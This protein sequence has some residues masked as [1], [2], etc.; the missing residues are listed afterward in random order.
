MSEAFE[1]GRPDPG[2]PVT[3]LA[4]MGSERGRELL[5]RI[6]RLTQS[7]PPRVSYPS[8]FLGVFLF[9]FL[10][11]SLWLDDWDSVLFAQALDGIDLRMHHPHPPGYPV[12][13][14]LA[15][16]LYWFLGDKQLALVL[17]SNLSAAGTLLLLIEL[18]RLLKDPAAGVIAA[19]V[20]FCA[21][22]FVQSGQVA[23]ADIVMTPLLVGSVVCFLHSKNRSGR[24]RT[25]L[26]MA[27]AACLG[28]GIGVRPQALLLLSSI[29]LLFVLRF[30]SWKGR[31]TLIASGLV[32]T[33]TW[34]IPMSLIH[35]GLSR[36]VALC[37][38]QFSA[39][40]EARNKFALED[41][42]SFGE[43]LIN[44][45]QRPLL[46]FL[47]LV[48]LSIGILA[49][50]AASRRRLESSLPLLTILLFMT[51]AGVLTTLLFHPLTF[52]RVLL[53]ALIPGAFLAGM[54]MSYGWRASPNLPG[55]RPVFALAFLVASGLGIDGS[56]S[57]ARALHQSVPPAIQAVHVIEQTAPA[58]A[59][60][61]LTTRAFRHWQYYLPEYASSGERRSLR[62][63]P[64]EAEPTLQ[65]VFS[66][67]LKWGSPPF[68]SWQFDRSPSIYNKLSRLR[69]YQYEL[70]DMN[71]FLNGGVYDSESWGF[72][73]SDRGEGIIRQ[74][75]DGDSRLFVR[76]RSGFNRARTMIVR[77]D[78]KETWSGEIPVA[79]TQF[80][81]PLPLEREW[82]PF[83]IESPDGCERPL[84]VGGSSDSRCLSFAIEHLD[85]GPTKI[86]LGQELLFTGWGSKVHLRNGWSTPE[87]SGTWS[88]GNQA[89]IHLNLRESPIENLSLKFEGRFFVHELHP[90]VTFH[91]SLNG[92]RVFSGTET[93]RLLT[94]FEIAV[95]F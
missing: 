23:M 88:N 79:S 15:R 42:A 9:F 19:I 95:P 56:L 64:W 1:V 51:V 84:E 68:Q 48:L 22:A 86:D 36:Y 89:S 91:V 44:D 34:L 63:L 18:G 20:L 7:V 70:A 75:A 93:D 25:L 78:G 13:V 53:P 62:W 60:V 61:L 74:A 46:L 55:F 3:R 4:I 27:G 21:P 59:T 24:G 80:E 16:V 14:F 31:A 39:H 12:Y 41:L 83:S 57:R 49:W 10:L 76:L 33:L 26:I 29:A 43:L 72:W 73:T 32:A 94:D 90:S 38:R 50:R 5:G 81:I 92:R 47:I 58:D 30:R 35:G 45:W 85:V 82:V 2:Q 71:V 40:P 87:T 11:R 54:A 52:K 66:D 28:Y 8:V 17:L 37:K 65:F 69:V 6:G 67:R 77:I